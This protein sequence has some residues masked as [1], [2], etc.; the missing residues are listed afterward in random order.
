MTCDSKINLYLNITLQRQIRQICNYVGMECRGNQRF[1]A[2]QPHPV[3][4]YPGQR[5]EG[6]QRKLL[7]FPRNNVMHII[8]SVPRRINTICINFKIGKNIT[9]QNNK[10]SMISI[11]FLS[12]KPFKLYLKHKRLW[13]S[14]CNETP[15]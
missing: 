11:F 15:Q 3:C 14:S 6:Y 8:T 12:N 13:N 5:T 10:W 4:D 9:A 1:D 2:D 7:C